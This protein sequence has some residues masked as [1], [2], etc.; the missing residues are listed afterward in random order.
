VAPLGCA[1]KPDVA[2]VLAA[3]SYLGEESDVKLGERQIRIR[4][5][6]LYLAPLGSLMDG[7]RNT[8]KK[9]NTLEI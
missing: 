2:Y 9:Y 8:R 1:H 4:W 7:R 6:S 5:V 3:S